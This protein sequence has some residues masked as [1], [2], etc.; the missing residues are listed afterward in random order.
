MP[1]PHPPKLT[2]KAI[3]VS[4][5]SIYYTDP[6]RALLLSLLTYVYIRVLE[7]QTLAPDSESLL[8]YATYY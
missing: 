4:L 2:V 5:S 6:T 7:E 8:L 1:R 3:C